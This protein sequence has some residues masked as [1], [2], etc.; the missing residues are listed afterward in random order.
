MSQ[1]WSFGETYR[2]MLA[3]GMEAEMFFGMRACAISA[4]GCD[5]KKHCSGQPDGAAFQWLLVMGY[6]L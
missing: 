2:C 3:L 1:I 4:F 6:R 5:A